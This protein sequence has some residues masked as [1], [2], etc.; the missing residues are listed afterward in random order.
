MYNFNPKLSSMH[1][2]VHLQKCML[3]HS[4]PSRLK[5]TFTTKVVNHSCPAAIFGLSSQV[6]CR[7]TFTVFASGQ[8]AMP[9]LVLCHGHWWA[10]EAVKYVSDLGNLSHNNGPLQDKILWYVPPALWHL[11]AKNLILLQ[12]GTNA[13]NW[14]FMKGACFSSLFCSVSTLKTKYNAPTINYCLVISPTLYTCSCRLS[15]NISTERENLCSTPRSNVDTRYT[16]QF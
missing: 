11:G 8:V 2:D 13:P 10:T 3:T 14:F 6:L 12:G 9:S 4:N 15:E 5:H 1:L 7:Y 16:P